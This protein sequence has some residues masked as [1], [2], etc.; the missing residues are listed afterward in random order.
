MVQ[1]FADGAGDVGVFKA[2]P[3]DAARAV[4][5]D[6]FDRADR[7]FGDLV[8]NSASDQQTQVVRYGAITA[9]TSTWLP[10]VDS[11]PGSFV[12]RTCRHTSDWPPE[13]SVAS[14]IAKVPVRQRVGEL[15]AGVHG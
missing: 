4:A 13:F 14:S 9:N 7:P 10:T 12:R 6:D 8:T 1:I 2:Q 3:H 15:P 5:A 11:P